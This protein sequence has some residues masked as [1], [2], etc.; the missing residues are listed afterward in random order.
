MNE[1]KRIGNELLDDIFANPFD[2]INKCVL[3]IVAWTRFAGKGRHGSK[4]YI[5]G[6]PIAMGMD[7]NYDELIVR[8]DRG[9]VTFMRYDIIS[10]EEANKMINK[11]I[12]DLE[13]ENER[14][15]NQV[16]MMKILTKQMLEYEG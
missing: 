7:G 2:Y 4:T 15:Q 11:R 13:R 14:L 16:K 5:A 12:A 3:N 10:I 8:T 1:V 6:I 9:I